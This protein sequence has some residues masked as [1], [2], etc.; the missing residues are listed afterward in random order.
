MDDVHIKIQENEYFIENKENPIR[1]LCLKDYIVSSD[2]N[3]N[4]DY[5]S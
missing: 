2:Q 4:F 3:I 5:D 1:N